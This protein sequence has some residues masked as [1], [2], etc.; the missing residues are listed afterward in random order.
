[1]LLTTAFTGDFVLGVALGV[2]VS[3]V[4]SVVQYVFT[5]DR[6]KMPELGTLIM[7]LVMSIKFFVD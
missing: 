3:A 1:M 5:M 4:I 7:A 2:I 6:S